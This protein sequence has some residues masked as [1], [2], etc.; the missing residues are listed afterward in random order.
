MP[1]MMPVVT[2]PAIG[3]MVISSLHHRLRTCFR[4]QWH[5]EHKGKHAKRKLFHNR[6]DAISLS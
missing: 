3:M 6:S 1:H 2:M 5:K 4:N